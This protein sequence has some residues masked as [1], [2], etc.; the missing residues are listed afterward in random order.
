MNMFID[1]EYDLQT[2]NISQ[3]HKW[4]A[5]VVGIKGKCWLVFV[6]RKFRY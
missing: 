2:M 4:Y 1:Y 6:G 5:Q 3:T